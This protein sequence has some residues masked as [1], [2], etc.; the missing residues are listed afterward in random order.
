MAYTRNGIKND[1]PKK[2]KQMYRDLFS[3]YGYIL[4]LC[5]NANENVHLGC[6]H[7]TYHN[8]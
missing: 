4:C 5:M 2:I 6:F 8:K 1:E 3:C 7:Y